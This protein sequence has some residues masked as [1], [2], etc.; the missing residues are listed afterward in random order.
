MFS[1]ETLNINLK[2][3]TED[4]IE[5]SH[6]LRNEYFRSLKDAQIQDGNVKVTIA[7]RKAENDTFVLDMSVDGMV[8]VQCDR[9][10]DDMEQVVKSDSTY[11]VKLGHNPEETDDTITVDENEGILRLGWFIY[12]LI[13]LAIPIKHVHAPGKCNDAM[14][15]KLEELSATRS[16]DEVVEEAVDPRWE[17]LVKLK[18]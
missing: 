3:I 4:F 17:K 10:L 15:K 7:L 14:T 12:E 18:K 16:G 9:C 8:I 2:A 11:L 1:L 6:I 5:S 13:A